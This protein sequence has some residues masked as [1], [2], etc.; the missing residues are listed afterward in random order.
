[1]EIVKVNGGL[2]SNYEVLQ[3]LSD[4]K[5]N[6][7][8]LEQNASTVVYETIQYLNQTQATQQKPELIAN[9][10]SK[11]AKF[12]LTKAEKLQFVNLLPTT[13][14]EIQLIVEESEER[15]T[16][17]QVEELLQIVESFLPKNKTLENE[18]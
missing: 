2:L 17:E 14:V 5:S 18:C 7:S 12:G 11:L 16:E 6:N 10:L 15:L 1:M 3:A 9:F 4:I 13:P 8:G